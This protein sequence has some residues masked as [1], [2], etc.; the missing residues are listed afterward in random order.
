MP[1]V[2]HDAENMED[3]QAGEYDA[4]SLVSTHIYTNA[5]KYER[6]WKWE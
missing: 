3:M 4:Y 5:G 6:V 2:G 1:M